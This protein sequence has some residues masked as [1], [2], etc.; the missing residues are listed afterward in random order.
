MIVGRFIYRDPLMGKQME[1]VS[2]SEGAS[3]KYEKQDQNT[4]KES[5]AAKNL[6]QTARWWSDIWGSCDWW[7][8]SRG[9]KR[10]T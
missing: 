3:R 1:H 10:Q 8:D 6:H 7:N 5:K 9:N 2:E 4:W